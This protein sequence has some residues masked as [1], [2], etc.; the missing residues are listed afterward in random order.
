VDIVVASPTKLLQ[1]VKDGNLFYRDVRWLVGWMAVQHDLLHAWCQRRAYAQHT[2]QDSWRHQPSSDQ[3]PGALR[4][5]HSVCP[6]VVCRAP[7]FYALIMSAQRH[8]AFNGTL[9]Q[10]VDEADTIF[11]EGWGEELGQVLGPLRAKAEPA[12]VVLVSATMTKVRGATG[13]RDCNAQ[14]TATWNR[15]PRLHTSSQKL[16]PTPISQSYP[17]V[18]R[19][20]LD[21]ALLMLLYASAC[22][23][24]Q[25]P[26]E[27]PVP[28]HQAPPDIQY[29]SWHRR[30]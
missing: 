12:S 18:Q 6:S 16:C 10:V 9:V 25:A 29:T 5:S 26:P 22:A 21:V 1:H 27:L 24:N 4:Y 11:A 19:A 8:F 23:A 17:G 14:Q 28:C 13:V 20:P 30:Q 3:N 15:T 7:G 2:R